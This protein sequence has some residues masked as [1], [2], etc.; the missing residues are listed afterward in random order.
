MGDAGLLHRQRQPDRAQHVRRFGHQRFGVTPRPGDADDEVIGVAHEPVGRLAALA[1]VVALVDGA[2]RRPRPGEMLVQ[3]AECDVGQQG[4]EDPALRGAGHRAHKAT[5]LAEDSGLQERLDQPQHA[6]VLDPPAHAVHQGRVVDAIEARLYVALHHPLVR[7]EGEVLNLGD[8]DLRSASRSKPVGA[9]LK[10]GLEDRLQ[11]QLEG[12]LHDAVADR[13]DPQ[14][15]QPAATFGDRA[16]LDRQRPERSCAQLLTK[17]IQE[18]LHAM[19]DFDLIGG[20][21]IDPGRA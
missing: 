1:R 18:P 11:H 17:L 15:A 9:R 8:R 6:L 16:L 13:R 2:H 10:V 4:R 19:P 7:A 12:G 3:G 5:V 14:V 21:P 20:L